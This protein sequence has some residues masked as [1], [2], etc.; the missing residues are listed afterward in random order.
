MYPVAW[1][2]SYCRDFES[3]VFLSSGVIQVRSSHPPVTRGQHTSNLPTVRASGANMV[4]LFSSQVSA[5][6]EVKLYEACVAAGITLL[7]IAH[8]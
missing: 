3:K 5:D 1:F 2:A 6:G 4:A 7:S 8:R